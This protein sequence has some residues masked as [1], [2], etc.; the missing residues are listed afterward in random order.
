[1]FGPKRIVCRN[2][3][4]IAIRHDDTVLAI[5]LTPQPD[6]KV[7]HLSVSDNN[8]TLFGEKQQ[9]I[10]RIDLNQS[11]ADTVGRFGRSVRKY[12]LIL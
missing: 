11:N 3:K 8:V 6:C 2:N 1:M 12:K 5:K 7:L 10:T 4:I 9:I